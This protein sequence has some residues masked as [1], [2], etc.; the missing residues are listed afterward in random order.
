ML[1]PL[2]NLVDLLREIVVLVGELSHLLL[3]KVRELIASD[4]DF[5]GVDE[6]QDVDCLQ[7]TDALL[8]ELVVLIHY[9]IE[10]LN[11]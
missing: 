8:F 7:Q 2:E 11:L 3:Q 6:L 5:V 1:S 9:N 10:Y 4:L